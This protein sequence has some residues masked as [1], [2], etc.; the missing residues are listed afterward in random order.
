MAGEVLQWFQ[1]M[2]ATHQIYDWPSLARDLQAKFGQSAYTNTEVA[3][4]LLTQT[5]S[6]ATYIKEFETLSI[7]TPGLSPSNLLHH[8]IAGLRPDIKREFTLFCPQLYSWP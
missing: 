5:G 6:L 8:F 7:R 1:W 2:H 4:K 3:I